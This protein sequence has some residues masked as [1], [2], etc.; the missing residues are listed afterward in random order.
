[1]LKKELWVGKKK[2]GVGEG[3]K[4][5]IQSTSTSTRI[6]SHKT[7]KKKQQQQHDISNQHSKHMS[8]SKTGEVAE[9]YKMLANP[10]FITPS[11]IT[12]VV[13]ERSKQFDK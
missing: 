13:S 7:S 5:V 10:V 6:P 9:N 11:R 1:M 3:G 12:A 2:T 4:I 8:R